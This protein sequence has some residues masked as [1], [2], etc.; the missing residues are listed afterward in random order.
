MAD[1]KQAEKTT[2]KGALKQKKTLVA[3]S[4]ILPNLI[5]FFVFTFVFNSCN[6]RAI[7]RNS[8]HKLFINM[9]KINILR[10]KT[11]VS[12]NKSVSLVHVLCHN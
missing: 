9:G 8:I 11:A 1:Q 10:N 3:W 4:F 5:G 12:G 6:I 7:I 2:S